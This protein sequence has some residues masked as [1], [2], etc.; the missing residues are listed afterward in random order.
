MNTLYFPINIQVITEFVDN[1]IT[2]ISDTFNVDESKVVDVV[3]D[4]RDNHC[5]MRTA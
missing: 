4:V 3:T 2:Q 1:D 5:I